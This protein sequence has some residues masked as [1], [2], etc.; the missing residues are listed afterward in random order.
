MC[1]VVYIWTSLELLKLTIFILQAGK[2]GDYMEAN[3]TMGHQVNREAMDHL[4]G[5]KVYKVEKD[6]HVQGM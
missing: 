2:P 3:E 5:L 6:Y 1:T 4:A